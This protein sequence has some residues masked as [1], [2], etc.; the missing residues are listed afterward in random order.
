ML[1]VIACRRR[2]PQDAIDARTSRHVRQVTI[3]DIVAQSLSCYG[4][5]MNNTATDHA[6]IVVKHTV[7]VPVA[8]AYGAF[9]NARERE[10]W[11]APSGTAIFIYDET[12]FRIGGR[13][14]ARC[15]AKDEPRFRVEA[16]YVDIVPLRR[17]VST[18]TIQR[19]IS[20]SRQISRPS[21]PCLTASARE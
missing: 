3:T 13:D 6:T 5:V 16:R 10:A 21:N 17:I 1:S 11:A 14:I 19:S 20:C 8:R 12:D 18:E 7:N 2:Q 15:G 9:A 4:F